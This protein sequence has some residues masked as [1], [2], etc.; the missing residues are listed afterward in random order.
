MEIKNSLLNTKKR[1]KQIKLN[2]KMKKKAIKYENIDITKCSNKIQL[3]FGPKTFEE[4]TTKNEPKKFLKFNEHLTL[5]YV[6]P[7]S[8]VNLLCN[9]FKKMFYENPMKKNI[10]STIVDEEFDKHF[11]LYNNL[12]NR[13]SHGYIG[14]I[15][16]K[17]ISDYVDYIN[18]TIF[19]FSYN[20]FGVAFDCSINKKILEE[21]NKII[22]CDIEDNIEYRK[23][24]IGNKK[25]LG[26]YN[27]NPDIIRENM[28][29]ENII[30]LKCIINDFINYYLAFEKKKKYAP[31]SLNIYETNYEISDR[32]PSIM[33]SHN[34]NGYTIEHKFED[35]NIWES[36]KNK[37]DEHF[38]T[39]VCFESCHSYK[40]IDRS[41]NIYI[42][43][44]S[45]NRNLFLDCDSLINIY[46][47]I[48]HFYK[49]IEFE[50]LIT[51]K[52][53][54]IFTI[55][56]KKLNKK[57]Y[58]SYQNFLKE[59]LLY[60][61]LLTDLVT[62][63]YC[64]T[65]DYLKSSS[66]YQNKISKNLIKEYK[67]LEKY[68]ENKLSIENIMETRKVSYIS[69][70]IAIISIIVA[71]FPII[72]DSITSSKTDKEIIKINSSIDKVNNNI[73]ESNKKTNDIKEQ[74]DKIIDSKKKG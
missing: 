30:E 63:N 35:F 44:K 7:K 43:T 39:N 28:L 32:V 52:R 5:L 1:K 40:S 74:L 22:D 42:Y 68:Y 26:R 59:S 3:L 31:I 61:T 9:N 64:Y 19:N 11:E 37:S 10:F 57:I 51:N 70:L 16:P 71:I 46:I 50:E 20:Y 56:T 72:Y 73:E 66:K 54:S 13:S 21:I 27:W 29:S 4:G 2:N 33:L 41:T 17:N 49:N 58:I 55:Y 69:L 47:L 8:N 36:F 60:Q 48:L 65:N 62:T 53:N 6:F 34:M 24:Y 12:N 45:E 14:H 18:L 23:Y 38:K 67:K 15:K 25:V